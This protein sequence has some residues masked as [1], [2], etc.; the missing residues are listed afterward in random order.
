[1]Y[2]QKLCPWC[3]EYFHASRI[4]QK[5]C[6]TQCRNA[7]NNHRYKE[8]M[9]PYKSKMEGARQQDLILASLLNTYSKSLIPYSSFKQLGIDPELALQTCY[10]EKDQVLGLEFV[11]FQLRRLMDEKFKIIPL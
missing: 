10:D 7:R 1:M 6:S 4:D 8:R 11:K 3:E 5:F 9:A 2:Y